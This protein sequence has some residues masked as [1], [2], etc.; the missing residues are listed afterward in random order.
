MKIRLLD[1]KTKEVSQIDLE[2]YVRGVV[3]GEM[4]T[5]WPI[6]ALR[7]Q[8]VAIRSYTVYCLFHPRHKLEGADVCTDPGHC[9]AYSDGQSKRALNA[10]ETTD[11]LIMR[12]KGQVIAA[13]YSACCGG[14]TQNC[15]DVWV[16]PLP[17]IRGVSCSCDGPVRGHRLGLCQEGARVMAA[18][19]LSYV[20]ILRHYY[21]GVD[22]E[23]MDMKND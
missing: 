9:Q 6:E 4:P 21:T 15:E 7:A 16:Q 14:H 10:V 3:I 5:G 18:A 19:G 12:Y 23:P 11:S 1:K 8:A 17:Y 20:E 13:Y 22:I 2:Y